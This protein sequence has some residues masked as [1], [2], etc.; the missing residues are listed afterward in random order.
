MRAILNTVPTVVLLAVAVALMLAVVVLAVWLIRR[1]VP[2]TRDGFHA[3]VSAP[4]LGVVAAVFGLLLAFV[5]IIAYQNY[6]NAAAD[7]SRE[8]D[9]LASIVRDSAALPPSDGDRVRTAVGAYAR[10][11]VGDEWPRMRDG[12]DSVA[13]KRALTGVFTAL[14]AVRPRS[15]AARAFYADSVRQLNDGLDA[16]RDRL[17]A[18][19]G[20]LPFEMTAL[21]LF[22]A[23]VILGYAL[24][25]GSP[26]FWFHTLGPAAIAVVVAFSLVVL[27]DLS[28]PFSGDVTISPQPYKNGG[29]A[30]FFQQSR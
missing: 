26:H 23:L 3:E 5:I 17:E 16:R 25:I 6:L 29:L 27:F 18:A 21:I 9:S 12:N 30:Q 11:V 8:A 14:Q 2:A 4:M 1:V 10:A 7:V 24:L 28:Y 13:A 15:P 20:G 19:R 22:S